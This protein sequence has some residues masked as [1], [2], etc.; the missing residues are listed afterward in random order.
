MTAF[1][2]APG[3]ARALDLRPAAVA[4]VVALLADGNT[5]PFIA[6][7]RKEATGGLDEVAIG[8]I[9]AATKAALALEARRDA[10][11]EAVA[12]Q[13]QLN[14]ALEAQIRAAA[15]RATLEDLYLPYKKKRQTRATVAE[16]R[17]LGPLAARVLAQPRDGDPIREARRFLGPEVPDADAALAGARDIAAAALSETA[18]I[19]AL[20]RGLTAAHGDLRSEAVKKATEGKRTAFEDYYDYREPLARVASHR[21]LAVDRGESE[22]CLRVRVEIDGDRMAARIATAAGI[23]PASPWAGELRAAV[24]DGYKRLLGPSIETELRAALRARAEAEAVDVFARNLE[25]LLLAAPYGRRRVIGIDPGF[26]T[27]CKCAALSETGR[28]LAHTTLYP[29]TTKA[30]A[31]RALVEFARAHRAEAVAVGNGTAGRE[32]MDFAREALSDAGMDAIVVSINEAGASVYSASAVAR[33]EF[34]DLDLTIRGAISI[35]RRLQDPLAELVK[36]D[37]QSLGVGQY[38][39]DVTQG[40]LVERL[41]AVV[42]RC[43]NRVGVQ[44]DTASAALLTH[45]AGIGPATARRIVEHRDAHGAFT[46]RRQLLDVKGLGPKAFEQAAGFLRIRG[47]AL[48]LD[49]SAVHPERYALVEQMARDLGVP[50][51][52]LVGDAAL[53]A[54]IDPRRYPEVGPLTFA[55]LVAELGKPGLDPRATFAPPRFRDDVQTI[56]DL[57]EGMVLE[58]VVTN[59]AAFGAFVDIGVHQD[60]LVHVSKLAQGFVRDPHAVVSVGQRIEVRVMAVDRDRSRISLSVKDV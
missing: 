16:A 41:G 40:L 46:S 19:R 9:E 26:R 2:P 6:R 34:P 18:A 14:A 47:A 53:A 20:V 33:E 8:A 45:V 37:P 23:R 21:A 36:V 31:D 32:T 7:Y 15:D 3:V 57:V 42:E 13:G 52:R 55:D 54:R 43:V 30:G 48:P 59:V 56:D 35:G 10:I 24:A 38:Q 1:D 12:G 51:A 17:G 60:G 49:D 11:L 39:H 25:D 44:L 29:H 50:V 58:G 28:F 5:V 22:G 27:G 4:A